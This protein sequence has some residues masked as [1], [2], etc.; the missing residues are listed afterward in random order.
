MKW[1]F[2]LGLFLAIASGTLPALAHGVVLE[3]RQVNS[4]EVLAQYDTGEPMANAQVLVYAPDQP[5]EAWQ[6]S[7][8]DEE[9]RFTFVPPA[10]RPG[11]WEVMVRQ[12][13]H[14]G[15]VSIPVEAGVAAGADASPAAEGTTAAEPDAPV[16]A[17]PP[18]T[19][20]VLAPNTS[21]SPAQRAITIG[22]VIWGFVGTA[23]FF[24]RG[25][26]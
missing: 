8:T 9:G 10:D 25:K 4:I 17:T 2:A 26:R 22:A 18:A 14:G 5:S 1:N 23:L 12:A 16:A 24:A 11:N 13:G 15:I 6:Q 3:H 7:T 19:S 20:S 21:L